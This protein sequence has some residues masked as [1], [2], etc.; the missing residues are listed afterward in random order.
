MTLEEARKLSCD[1]C[2]HYIDKGQDENYC[3]I[4]YWRMFERAPHQRRPGFCPIY[5]RASREAW[6]E[7]RMQDGES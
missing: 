5:K 7:K 3:K 6:A 4:A 2:P 1:N